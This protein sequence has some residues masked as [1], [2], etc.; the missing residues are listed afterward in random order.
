MASLADLFVNDAFGTAH[1]AH[2][3]TEGVTKFLKPN[4]SG[5]L[6][7]KELDYLKGA[8]DAP[9]KPMAAIVGGVVL[10]LVVNI[11]VGALCG[12]F[13]ARA[14]AV[15]PPDRRAIV[16]SAIW[17]LLALG[18]ALSIAASATTIFLVLNLDKIGR[19]HV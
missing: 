3:S 18:W 11:I 1:R 9:K 10:G 5:F 17:G 7:K 14:V 19:A 13:T 4:V 6:L 8:V 16:P 2:S 15:V 12:F